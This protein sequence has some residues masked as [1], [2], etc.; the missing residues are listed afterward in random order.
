[1]LEISA[2]MPALAFE[3]E[4]KASRNKRQNHTG[5][6]KTEFKEPASTIEGSRLASVSN[7][8]AVQATA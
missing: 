3:H 8:P 1:M 2:F 6:M 7:H 4:M 5:N